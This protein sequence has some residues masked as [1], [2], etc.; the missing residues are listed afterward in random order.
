M[1]SLSDQKKAHEQ[2]MNVTEADEMF[3][4][5]PK[6]L[7]PEEKEQLESE[8][9]ALRLR[10]EERYRREQESNVRYWEDKTNEEVN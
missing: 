6:P 10:M 1:R 3:Y 2:R 7:T 9:H 4:K 5:E 8:Y